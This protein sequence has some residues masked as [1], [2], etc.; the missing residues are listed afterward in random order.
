MKQQTPVH[1]K[2]PPGERVRC[3]MIKLWGM[4]CYGAL[5][6]PKED[7]MSQNEQLPSFIAGF[8]LLK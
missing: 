7:G 4:S 2:T 3:P 6:L 8:D 1:P 5:C